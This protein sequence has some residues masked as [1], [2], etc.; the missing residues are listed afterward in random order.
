MTCG[1]MGMW[2]RDDEEQALWTRRVD[3]EH[4]GEHAGEVEDGESRQE[5]GGRRRGALGMRLIPVARA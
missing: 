3:G 5:E 1:G 2:R 4:A